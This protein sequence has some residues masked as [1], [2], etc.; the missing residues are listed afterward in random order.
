MKGFLLFIFLCVVAP[1]GAWKYYQRTHPVYRPL[2]PREEITLTII[3]GWNLRD[4]ADYLVAKGVA[5]STHDVYAVTGEPADPKDPTG[6]AEGALA[7]ETVRF[8][9]GVS[10]ENVV[11]TF[12]DLRTKQLT[13]EMQ[14]EVARRGITAP[15]LLI[16][17]SIVEKEARTD[18]D[19]KLVADILWRRVGLGWALQVDSS[20][21]YA[22]DKTGTVFTSDKERS[23]S[24]PW[25]TYK[26]RGLPPGPIC[27]PSVESIQA[28]LYP[29]KN[30][31]WYFLS[32]NDGKMHYAQT[33]DEHNT[34]RV[35]YLK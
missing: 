33:L 2:P 23:V 35:K 28:A 20:V 4:I 30:K 31:Y 32:G 29:E 21:H 15:E 24:S 9:K 7:P 11:K 8:F 27:M 10:I 26:Y 17:A 18:E 5:S 3:P 14:T 16:M 34:N 6:N 12:H 19:R 13:A 22:V 25:N 1:F